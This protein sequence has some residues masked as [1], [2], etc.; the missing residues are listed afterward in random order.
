MQRAERDEKPRQKSKT[1]GAFNSFVGHE[2]SLSLLI[3]GEVCHDRSQLPDRDKV[4]IDGAS[5]SGQSIEQF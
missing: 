1:I 2:R 3:A 5:R 4:A